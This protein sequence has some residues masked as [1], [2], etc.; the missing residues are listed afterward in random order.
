[1]E[2]LEYLLTWANV[3][4]IERRPGRT[5]QAWRL[6]KSI[7][8]ILDSCFYE[9]YVRR[10][11]RKISEKRNGMIPARLELATFRVLGGRDNHY[12][13][14]SRGKAGEF[15]RA[16]YIIKLDFEKCV[17]NF[18]CF[19][20]SNKTWKL[21]KSIRFILDSCFYELYVRRYWRN[22]SE[23]KMTRK[24]AITARFELATF[25]MW[26]R[27]WWP[28][29]HEIAV[30]CRWVL[31]LNI[32]IIAS[33]H[34]KNAWKNFHCISNSLLTTA[35]INSQWSQPHQYLTQERFA[36]FNQS[37]PLSQWSVSPGNFSKNKNVKA[38][39]EDFLKYETQA[40]KGGARLQNTWPTKYQIR[41]HD[42]TTTA[43][44]HRGSSRSTHSEF[45]MIYWLRYCG[46][47]L[48]TNSDLLWYCGTAVAVV[49]LK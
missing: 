41:L 22:F 44:Q 15:L 25:R 24:R 47:S 49:Q 40:L 39:L 37:E 20:I 16:I 48:Q 32:Q 43:L 35:Y 34:S 4:P 19:Y 8:F 30:I 28:L 6:K 14:E 31:L 29:H 5:I 3:P 2:K 10:D 1:M 42:S 38:T 9:L 45:I 46:S 26:R 13:T 11:L 18:R 33:L 23:K 27:L 36:W 12:T 21:W 7:R 17:K